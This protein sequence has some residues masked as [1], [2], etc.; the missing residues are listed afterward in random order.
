LS[1]IRLDTARSYGLD[2]VIDLP[3]EQRQELA[4][5]VAMAGGRQ[6]A[7]FGTYVFGPSDPGV[8]LALHLERSV[9]AESFGTSAQQLVDDFAP[10][11]PASLYFCVIDHRRHLPVGAARVI[12]PNR[13]GLKSLDDIEIVWGQSVAEVLDRNGLRFEEERAWDIATLAVAPGYRNRLVS[14]ALHQAICRAT[15]LCDVDWFVSVLD[16]KVLRLLQAQ[17]KH[18]FSL[19]GGVDPSMY[20]G[21]L[22]VPVWSD[23]R[24][25]RARLRRDH[26][27]L[28]ETLFEGRHLDAVVS[29]SEANAV[30]AA[31]RDAGRHA[32][33]VAVGERRQPASD[34]AA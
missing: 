5:A 32:P 26:S 15:L 18:V 20:A 2:G 14:Q 24:E 8:E 10:Y 21:S 12:V 33:A 17:L 6:H 4:E 27:D 16:T 25:Y 11:D 29:C 30:T 3:V 7:P 13:V 19:F 9:F 1:E 34:R 23:L 22:S 28:Y 31:A